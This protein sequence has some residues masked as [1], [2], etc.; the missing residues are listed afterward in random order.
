MKK[1]LL[2]RNAVMYVIAFVLIFSVLVNPTLLA[3]QTTKQETLT[4]TS[5]IALVHAKMDDDF[6]KDK[7]I[8]SPCKFSNDINSI[9][10]LKKSGVSNSIIKLMNDKSNGV[11]VMYAFPPSSTITINPDETS[12]GTFT[13][14]NNYIS[15]NGQGRI[16]KIGDTILLGTGKRPNGEFKSIQISLFGDT[17][18]GGY[19]FERYGNKSYVITSI[20]G[21]NKNKDKQG[22]AKVCI[23][24]NSTSY[25][26]DI[27][28]ALDKS[29][30][31]IK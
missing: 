18:R 5:I 23:K 17:G 26:I 29:I 15:R 1:Q 24:V 8:K 22:T 7:I 11:T 4:N 30:K 20:K 19:L 21:F 2:T 9:I 31:E 27:E 3:A 14:K 10:A 6:I 13:D 12:W 25:L 28:S 16:F